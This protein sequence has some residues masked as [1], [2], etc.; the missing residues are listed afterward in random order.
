MRTTPFEHWFEVGSQFDRQTGD[1]REYP[2]LSLAQRVHAG[3]SHAYPWRLGL[4]RTVD[5][6]NAAFAASFHES[7]ST[8]KEIWLEP[9]NLQWSGH[10]KSASFKIDSAIREKLIEQTKSRRECKRLL[11]VAE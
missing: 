1:R 3:D 5:H 11:R 8:A 10:Q 2:R 4:R 6:A 9:P 7:R